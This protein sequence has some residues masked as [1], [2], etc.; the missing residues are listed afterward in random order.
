MKHFFDDFPIFSRFISIDQQLSLLLNFTLLT[1]DDID[2]DSNALELFNVSCNYYLPSEIKNIIDKLELQNK[3]L[4]VHINARSLEN[5]LNQ[6]SL[7][8][9]S[10]NVDIDVIA[11]T[12]SWETVD[13]ADFLQI[14]GYLKVSNRRQDGRNGGG[15]ALFINQKLI[16]SVKDIVSATFESVFIEICNQKSK[17]K[18]IIWAIYRPPDTDHS[19]FNKEF[20]NLI[21]D[22]SPIKSVFL[23]AT[24]I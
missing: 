7:L 20:Q 3:F 2:P 6:V 12:E 8:T 5:K 16:F 18:T 17:R 14:H 10:L 15:V 4:V 22:L 21:I 23:Q 11:V 19:L 24:I 9:T 1:N 13:N